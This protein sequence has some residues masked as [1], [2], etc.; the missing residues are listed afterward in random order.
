MAAKTTLAEKNTPAKPATSNANPPRTV[1][2]RVKTRHT[3]A[4]H[5]QCGVIFDGSWKPLTL[6]RLGSAYKAITTDSRLVVEDRK[7]LAP[8][9]AE[10]AVKSESQ[11]D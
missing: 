2:V 6:D 1:H 4:K 10:K 8:P 11:S 9:E 7:P 5:T 3:G